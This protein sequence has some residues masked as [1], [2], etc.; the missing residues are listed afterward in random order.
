MLLGGLG[1]DSVSVIVEVTPRPLLGDH[2]SRCA[3]GSWVAMLVGINNYRSWPP[4]GTA[5]NDAKDVATLLFRRG[6]VVTLLLNPSRH[7]WMSVFSRCI[8]RL[9]PHSTVV[10]YFSGHGCQ[11]GGVD[12]LAPVDS[13]NGALPSLVSV[14]ELVAQTSRAMA[15]NRSGDP[16]ASERGRGSGVLFVLLDACRFDAGADSSHVTDEL[17][18]R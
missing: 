18:S 4:L 3:D 14:T 8:S 7:K 6:Y 5:E 2:L 11:L 17:D 12:F 16:F 15:L 13:V 9:Q 1:D 10:L